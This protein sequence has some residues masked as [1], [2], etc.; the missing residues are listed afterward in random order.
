VNAST[1]TRD[2]IL[3]A[4]MHLFGEH[5]FKGTS[6]AQIERAA[7]LTPGAG[8][9]YHHFRSKD[10]VLAAGL[11]RHLARIGALRDIRR[12]FTGVGDLR[13]ELT[14]TARYVLTGL[15]DE[16]ELLQVLALEARS[17][18]EVLR[19]A[20]GTLVDGT[21]AEFAAWLHDSWEVPA[22]RARSLTAIALGALVSHRLLNGFFPTRTALSDDAFVAAWVETFH[23]AIEVATG[24]AGEE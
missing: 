4:A 5:G 19:D 21:Y 22:D 14:L 7:G 2:R 6:V 20:V 18:P 15:Q 16:G 3:D 10:A 11:D 24:Q 1:P 9:L 12:L 8:G 23:P 13:V 17:R